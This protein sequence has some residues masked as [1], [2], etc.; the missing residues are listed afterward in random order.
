MAGNAAYDALDQKAA[1]P[2]PARPAIAA[3][4]PAYNATDFIRRCIEGLIDAGFA[5]GEI[6]IVDDASSDDTARI[7]RESGVVPLR[8]ARNSGAAEARNAGARSVTADILFFVDADVVVHPCSRTRI[9]QFFANKPQYAAIFGAYDSDPAA[10]T[11][12]SRFRNLL[13]RHVHLEGHGDQVTFWTGCGALRCESFEKI[14][15]F[16]PAQNMMEDVKLG[17]AL[18]AHGERIWLD[19]ALQGKHLKRWTLYSMARTDL[20]HRAIPWARL[21]RTEMGSA[22]GKSLNLRLGGKLSGLAVAG[23]LV[24][25]PLVFAAPWAAGAVLAASLALLASANAAFLR[26]LR[27]ERGLIEAFAAIP[28]LWLHYLCACLGY[29]WVLLTPSRNR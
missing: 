2:S 15:G 18:S 14:G 1:E 21:L 9:L 29:A 22:S 6:I 23:S 17:L 26:M 11:L 8:L 12:V 7:T 25:L 4:V 10:D 3:I 13:H 28:L 27:R 16:D 24:S 20:L 19:S 5:P